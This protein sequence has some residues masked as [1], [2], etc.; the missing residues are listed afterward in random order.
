M[1]SLAAGSWTEKEHC[2]KD[3]TLDAFFAFRPQPKTKASDF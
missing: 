3:A 1:Q 2:T